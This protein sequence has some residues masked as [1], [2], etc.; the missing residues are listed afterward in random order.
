MTEA[1]SGAWPTG[2][3]PGS[4]EGWRRKPWLGDDPSAATGLRFPHLRELTSH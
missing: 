2:I 4:L 3:R 1:E